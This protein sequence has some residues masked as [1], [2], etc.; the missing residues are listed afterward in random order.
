MRSHLF[1]TFITALLQ[2]LGIGGGLLIALA[3]FKA[4]GG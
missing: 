3:L 4:L 2:G 1:D